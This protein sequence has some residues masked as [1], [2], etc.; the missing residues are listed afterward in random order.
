M[1]S[2]APYD[3]RDIFGSFHLVK[4]PNKVLMLINEKEVNMYTKSWLAHHGIKGQQ[5]GVRRGPPYPIEDKVLAK[6]TVLNSVYGNT[7][8]KND[9]NIK[10]KWTYTYNPSDRWDKQVYEGPFSYYTAVIRGRNF[11]KSYEYKTT[12]D[13]RMPTKKERMEPF[14]KLVNTKG[15]TGR[16]YRLEMMGMFNLLKQNNV[17]T[18]KLKSAFDTLDINNLKT[19]DDWDNAYEIFNHM[20][21]NLTQYKITQAYSKTMA[22][23]YDAMV[24]D[25]NAVKYNRAHDPIIIFNGQK[26]LEQTGVRN[27]TVPEIMTNYYAVKFVLDE[28]GERVKL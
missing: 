16:M 7:T 3:R 25:N 13:L 20:M 26:Y 21:E 12:K 2:V 28:Y 9:R 5:W 22:K 11:I 8:N 15:I 6:G 24:D 18:D 14:K 1:R 17:G 10:G 4:S 19:D 27:L 23:N